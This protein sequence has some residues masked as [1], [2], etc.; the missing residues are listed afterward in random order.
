MT[1]KMTIADP[2][3][4]MVARVSKYGQLS[5][6]PLSFS[7][8]VAAV[9]TQDDTAYNFITPVAEHEVIITDILLSTNRTIGANGA[10]IEVYCSSSIDGTAIVTGCSI[11]SVELL[12]NEHRDLTGLNFIVNAGYWVNIKTN[13]T[14]VTATIAYYRVPID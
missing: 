7:T 5:T 6:A 2:R 14:D 11:L 10:D 1:V 13:D 9:L 4:G 8:P 3:S 12:K